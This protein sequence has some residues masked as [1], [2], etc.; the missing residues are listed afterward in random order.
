MFPIFIGLIS[1]VCAAGTLVTSPGAAEFTVESL[2]ANL[3]TQT[4]F[5]VT[6]IT[7][8]TYITGD[9]QSLYI[10]SPVPEVPSDGYRGS[11]SAGVTA[12][13]RPVSMVWDAGAASAIFSNAAKRQAAEV[14]PDAYTLSI[15]GSVPT[16]TFAHPPSS[17]VFTEGGSVQA[18]GSFASAGPSKAAFSAAT[19]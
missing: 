8:L 6:R 15:L 18:E 19:S 2:S 5:P 17:G 4:V 12:D 16:G 14:S 9:A 13:S 1:A 11:Q 10:Q 7:T 3:S